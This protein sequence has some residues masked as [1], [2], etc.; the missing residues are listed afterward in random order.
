MQPI[1][2]EISEGMI[3]R[4]SGAVRGMSQLA[5]TYADRLAKAWQAVT[6]SWF[7]A[8]P[9]LPQ[10]SPPGTPTRRWDFPSGRNLNYYPRGG[11]HTRFEQ[12]WA[13]ADNYPLLRLVIETRKDQLARMPWVIRP[14]ALVTEEEARRSEESRKEFSW[15]FRDSSAPSAVKKL[16]ELFSYPDGEHSFGDWL[17]PLAEDLLVG[18]CLTLE[19]V[20]NLGGWLVELRPLSGRT[21]F[22]VIDPETGYTPKPPGVAYQQ[23]IKGVIAADFTADELIYRP[24]NV[25]LFTT[26]GFS[27]VEQVLMTINT[28]LRYDMARLAYFTDGEVPDAYFA[29]PESWSNEQMNEVQ[30][31]FDAYLSGNVQNRHKIIVGP[32]GKLQILKQPELK[33]E[34]DEWLARIICYAFSVSPQPFV[35]EMNRATAQTAKESSLEEGLQPLLTYFAEL[36]NFIIRKYCGITDLEFAWQDKEPE[37][38]TAE[39]NLCAELV[40]SAVLTPN[41]A[42]ARLGL[43]PQPGGDRLGVITANGF[44]AIG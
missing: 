14:K 36:F 6:S 9:P 5:D 7:S 2:I 43:P 33:T 30:R 23:I 11:N 16:T 8:L 24:R 32:E 31:N 25:R 29:A 1:D 17:R 4:V 10:A 41:E 42:R 18:D 15:I 3:A 37:D 21:I 13:L 28:G 12:L 19:P 27:P 20:K 38:Q 26:Y 34:L 44:T 22:P 40:K 35:R 39:G